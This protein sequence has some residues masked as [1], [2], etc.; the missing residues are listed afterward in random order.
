MVVEYAGGLAN[1]LG[2]ISLS[3]PNSGNIGENFW[4]RQAIRA[5]LELP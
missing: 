2:H 4:V 5:Y 1:L 3:L